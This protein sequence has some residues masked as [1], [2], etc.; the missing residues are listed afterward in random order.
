MNGNGLNPLLGN[1]PSFK[2]EA[3]IFAAVDPSYKTYTK[4]GYIHFFPNE[5]SLKMFRLGR[6]RKN[7]VYL[8]EIADKDCKNCYGAGRGGVRRVPLCKTKGEI[9]KEITLFLKELEKENIQGLMENFLTNMCTALRFPDSFKKPLRI[10]MNV[11]KKEFHENELNKPEETADKF[12]KIISSDFQPVQVVFCKCFAEN[13][14]SEVKKIKQ[15]TQ[16]S[17]N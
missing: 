10:L 16:F 9:A 5:H 15:L 6:I 17:M 13:L 4:E 1:N 7:V 14:A 11:A 12:A 3:I 2:D 8:N